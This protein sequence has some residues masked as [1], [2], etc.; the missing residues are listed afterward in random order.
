[1]VTIKSKHEIELMKAAGR[2][3]YEALKKYGTPEAEEGEQTEEQAETTAQKDSPEPEDGSAEHLLVEHDRHEEREYYYRGYIEYHGLYTRKQGLDERCVREECVSVVLYSDEFEDVAASLYRL[4]G[5]E[6]DP[7]RI[8]D[9]G[10]VYEHNTENERENENPTRTLLLSLQGRTPAFYLGCCRRF[11][12]CHL[13]SP[14][15]FLYKHISGNLRSVGGL[16]RV[17]V[18]VDVERRAV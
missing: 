3:T 16:N 2:I 9:Y 8:N 6:A 15:L 1:M 11:S 18:I 7:N 14:F 4:E 13:F 12:I 17:I 5:I 10:Q